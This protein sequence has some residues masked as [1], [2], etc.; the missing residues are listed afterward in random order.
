MELIAYIVMAVCAYAALIS[1]TPSIVYG[2]FVLFVIYSLIA[3]LSPQATGDMLVYYKAAE[4]WPVPP[5]FYHLR[6][7]VLWYGSSF[8]YQLLNDRVLTFL[9]IDIFGGTIVLRAMKT[10]DDGDNC[11][12]SFAPCIV[13]SY[14]FL[15]G[16]QNVLRQHLAFAIL[17]WALAARFRNRRAAFIPF[18]LSVLTH[19]VTAVLSGYWFDVGRKGE[20]RRYGPLITVMCVVLIGITLPFIRK[21]STVTGLDTAYLYVV[22]AAVIGGL[23]LYANYGRLSM[24]WSASLFNFVAFI[25]AIGILTSAQFERLSMMFLVLILVDIYRHHRML[26]LNRVVVA[27]LAY[28]VLVIP[29][30]LF[31]SS[32]VMLR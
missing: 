21:S 26:R 17:L 14:V 9:L 11:M 25:P 32:L 15:L 5:T 12:F 27:H 8:L 18:V 3:R 20:Q 16:Q 4:T 24:S 29:T 6:E 7:P 22:L 19:N 13:S 30:L 23:L 31:S 2:W 1:R 28:G 10:L